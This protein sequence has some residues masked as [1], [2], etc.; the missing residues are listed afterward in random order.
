MARSHEVRVM[1]L[2]P[3][4]V[5]RRKATAASLAVNILIKGLVSK[6]EQLVV[7]KTSKRKK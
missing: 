5:I 7:V 4:A 6:T 3:S 2:Q 1:M